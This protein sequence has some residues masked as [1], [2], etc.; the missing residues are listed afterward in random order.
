M[1]CGQL[2]LSSPHVHVYLNFDSK[3]PYSHLW[4]NR[5]G[6]RPKFTLYHRRI[7]CGGDMGVW[8]AAD[9]EM[10]IEGRSYW[11]CFSGVSWSVHDP[12]D[13][14]T[15]TT[16]GGYKSPHPRYCIL[17]CLYL[18]PTNTIIFIRVSH[19]AKI[20]IY[21][22]SLNLATGVMGLLQRNCVA[23]PIIDTALLN[24]M[25]GAVRAVKVKLTP[26]DIRS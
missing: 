21:I 16:G 10:V 6:R 14:C 18:A 26:E 5:R 19:Q 15:T 22:T 8:F 12:H 3:K 9:R 1:I 23:A 13:L 2:P 20:L 24:N 25:E 11:L 7:P 17:T 4:T